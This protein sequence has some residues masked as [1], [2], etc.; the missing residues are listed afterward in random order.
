MKALNLPPNTKPE[1]LRRVIALVIDGLVITQRAPNIHRID[2]LDNLVE[3][4]ADRAEMVAKIPD[5]PDWKDA[6]K[7]LVIADFKEAT[8]FAPNA[9]SPALPVVPAHKE[10]AEANLA[11][12]LTRVEK[13]LYNAEPALQGESAELLAEARSLR[14]QVQDARINVI[15][16]FRL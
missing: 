12:Y 4:I 7:A 10:F 13:L 16:L 1:F 11:T 5:G 3:T 14:R 8:G 15:T 2:D 9:A 6:A